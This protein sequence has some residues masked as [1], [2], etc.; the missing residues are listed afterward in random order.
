MICHKTLVAALSVLLLGFPLSAVAEVVTAPNAA[1]APANQLVVSGNAC[2]PTA[3]LNAFRMG[4]DSWQRALTGLSG[5]NDKARIYTIIRQ[6]GM[7]PSK[8]LPGKSRWSRKGVNIADLCDIANEMTA[9]KFLPQVS[10]EVLFR[11]GKESPEEL[12]KRIHKRLETSLEKGFPPLISLRRYALRKQDGK[13]AAWIVLD[14]HFVTLTEIPA[15]LDK[16]ARSFPVTYIDPW[17]GKR[18]QG[19]I[20][21]PDHAILA[22]DPAS[23]PCAEAVFPQSSVGK[24]LVKGNEP[25]ALAVA[26]LLGRW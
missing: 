5:D 4:N 24:K 8:H 10:H 15:K 25:N 2:G 7:R 14:A 3:L 12:L 18:S 19:T 9:G 26:A 6:Y 11:T 16:G 20:A 21:L 23:S 17:G 13:P 1:A 22:P